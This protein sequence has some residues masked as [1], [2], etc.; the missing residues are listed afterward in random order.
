MPK[1]IEED[2]RPYVD[3]SENDNNYGKISNKILES[4]LQFIS[5]NKKHEL[6]NVLVIYSKR[7]ETDI[8]DY[9]FAYTGNYYSDTN[10]TIPM[11]K[12]IS[13]GKINDIKNINLVLFCQIILINKR[14]EIP[15]K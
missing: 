9:I 4:S 13:N 8:Q 12:N 5:V 1:E 10:E 6:P 7:C 11:F 2:K 14:G 3:G 15:R